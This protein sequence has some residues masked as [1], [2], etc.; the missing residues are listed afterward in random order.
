[1]EKPENERKALSEKKQEMDPLSFKIF[2]TLVE[3][4][5]NQMGCEFEWRVVDSEEI[6]EETV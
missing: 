5:G 1:M 6:I 2:S 4:Y 3:L